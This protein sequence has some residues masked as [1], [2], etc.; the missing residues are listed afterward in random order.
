LLD[1]CHAATIRSGASADNGPLQRMAMTFVVLEHYFVGNYSISTVMWPPSV[2]NPGNWR[3]FRFMGLT[4]GLWW[5]VL[6][7][8]FVMGKRLR[9]S[10]PRA[11]RAI[12]DDWLAVSVYSLLPCSL[13]YIVMVNHSIV[14]VHFLYRH[15]FFC[16]FLFV[17]FCAT[18]LAKELS[19]AAER[20][21][22]VFARPLALISSMPGKTAP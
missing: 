7:T 17:L 11:S 21:R 16:F 14:H 20:S 15:L 1:L 8:V 10:P 3:V 6:T 12:G 9:Y 2:G 22:H 19:R 18:A 4:L 13:W 5:L